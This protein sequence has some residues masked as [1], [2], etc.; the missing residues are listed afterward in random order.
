MG[1]HTM[2]VQNMARPVTSVHNAGVNCKGVLV[3]MMS[4]ARKGLAA[5]ILLCCTLP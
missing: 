5:L 2:G 3:S 1:V 4:L